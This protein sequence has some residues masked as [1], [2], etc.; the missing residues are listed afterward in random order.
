MSETIYAAVSIFD[1]LE[2]VPHFLR[3]YTR[4]GVNKIVLSVRGKS[5]ELAESVAKIAVDYPTVV[6]FTPAQYFDC[7]ERFGVENELL[8][9]EGMQ[10]DN[11]VLHLD[12][13]EFHEYPAPLIDIVRQMN[14]ADAWA[15]RGWMVDRVAADGVL[16]PIRDEP[17]I[18]EQFPLAADITKSIL[19]AL[20]QKIMLCRGR[21]HLNSGKH[22]TFNAYYD[23]VPLGFTEQYRVH[24]FKWIDGVIERFEQR[25]TEP[26]TADGYKNECR[27]FI[28]YYRTYGRVDLSHPW[29][30]VRHL[31]AF[32][33]HDASR[34]NRTTI[35][36]KPSKA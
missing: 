19:A 11:Y 34:S 36:E 7:M 15:V 29:L 16:H 10:D 35:Q 32:A 21:V 25:I 33:Y 24:H 3:H 14:K 30:N 27:S 28:K 12:L 6:H 31:G 13:D 2:I 5:P 18:S 17:C 9:R 1:N 8:R 22:D 20:N 23:R 26:G 4:L